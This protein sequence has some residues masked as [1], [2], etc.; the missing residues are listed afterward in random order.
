M[1]IAGPSVGGIVGG[2]LSAIVG[3]VVVAIIVFFCV[4]RHRN[5]TGEPTVKPDLDNEIYD[6][7]NGPTESG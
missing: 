5:Y 3:L 4:K 2:V 7:I 6:V 1:L